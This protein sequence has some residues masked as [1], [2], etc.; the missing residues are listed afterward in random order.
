M[1]EPVSNIAIEDVLSSIRRLV[2]E[3]GRP[4]DRSAP[5]KQAE[6]PARL[7]LTEALRVSTQDEKPADTA[8]SEDNAKPQE[9]FELKPEY[10]TSDEIQFKHRS[11]QPEVA[12]SEH[13][14]DENSPA[15]WDDP[16]ATLHQAAAEAEAQNGAGSVTVDVT[17]AEPENPEPTA[18]EDAQEAQS[19]IDEHADNHPDVDTEQPVP[20]WDETE[21]QIQSPAEPAETADHGAS[22]SSKIKALE[23]AIAQSQ[24]RWEPDDAGVDDYAGTRGE[25]LTWQDADDETAGKHIREPAEPKPQPEPVE[26]NSDSLTPQDDDAVAAVEPEQIQ[27]DEPEIVEAEAEVE[28]N[29]EEESGVSVDDTILDEASLRELVT[30]IV[31]EELQGALGE[32][33]T[34]NVRKLVRREIQRALTSQELE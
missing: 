6:Q 26:D 13:D 27:H 1:S 31:R 8:A 20:Q 30:D 23:A 5:S 4:G 17:Y 22:L 16:D 2:T 29:A 11:R 19:E 24:D 10:S 7:V 3:E 25:A 12:D 14:D 33:I 9:P 18:G 34:R 21:D 32:R 28:V 15:P